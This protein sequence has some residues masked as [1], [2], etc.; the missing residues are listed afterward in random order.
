M[1]TRR[2]L[3]LSLGVVPLAAPA[4]AAEDPLKLRQL[5]N[6]DRSFSD[7][8]MSL[9]GRMVSVEGFMAPPL[10]ADARFF[11]LTKMPMATCPFCEP[12]VEW[13]RNILPVYTRR[14]VDVI[15]FNVRIMA[16]GTLNLG[17]FTDP[18]TGFWS[19]LRLGN[20]RYGRA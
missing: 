10:K 8:A 1:L 20:A 3:C 19:K 15:P 5:Y 2:A 13:P 9:K 7:L 18:D 4:L 11:V 17:D 14:V 6:K 12:G 16:T